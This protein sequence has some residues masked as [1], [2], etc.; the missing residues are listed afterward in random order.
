MASVATDGNDILVW[1]KGKDQKTFNEDDDDIWDDT[2]LI[3]AYDRAVQ[4]IKEELSKESQGSPPKAAKTKKGKNKIHR[5]SV[6]D[7]CVCP[8]MED[9]LYYPAQIIEVDQDSRKALVRYDEFLNEEELDLEDLLVTTSREAKKLLKK[10]KKYYAAIGSYS[11][12][13][14]GDSS[15]EAAISKSNTTQNSK[16]VK[17]WCVSDICYAPD[18][19]GTYRQAVVNSIKDNDMCNV[20]FIQSRQKGE[21]NTEL[22]SSQPKNQERVDPLPNGSNHIPRRANFQSSKNPWS[23][24]SQH[25]QPHPNASSYYPQM[26]QMH[27]FP[28]HRH[29]PNMPPRVPWLPQFPPQMQSQFSGVPPRFAINPLPFDFS[30]N[31]HPQWHSN[32]SHHDRSSGFKLPI[33]PPPP[34]MPKHADLSDEENLGNMLMSWYMSGYHTGYYAATQEGATGGR[35]NMDPNM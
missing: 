12:S 6:N 29:I 21:V 3:Q 20:T 10:T 28:P 9:G 27:N 5:W 19:T 23:S 15:Q 33:F 35:Q 34:A 25:T 32:G 13:E 17:K 31:R 24:F 30:D 18:A 14:T 1:K 7:K 11:T 16:A 8:Y 26:P 2:E 4:S 22:L